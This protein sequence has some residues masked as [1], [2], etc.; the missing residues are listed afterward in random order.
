[1]EHVDRLRQVLE[2]AISADGKD[3]EAGPDR[4]LVKWNLYRDAATRYRTD[5]LRLAAGINGA[6]TGDA[7]QALGMLEMTSLSAAVDYRRRAAEDALGVLLAE[8]ARLLAPLI[9]GP[10]ELVAECFAAQLASIAART[11]PD[12]P[13]APPDMRP[14]ILATREDQ[15]AA[16]ERAS[17]QRLERLSPVE[18]QRVPGAG[19]EADTS[20]RARA[21]EAVKVAIPVWRRD[22]APGPDGVRAFSVDWADPVT[23][24][25]GGDAEL[26]LNIGLPALATALAD[27]ERDPMA[28]L[29]PL[30]R[31]QYPP[32]RVGDREMP[33]SEVQ[34]MFARPIFVPTATP[35][36][37]PPGVPTSL[38]W[39]PV[40]VMSTTDRAALDG[41]AA[42]DA[43]RDAA[44]A[45]ARNVVA[46]PC[47]RCVANKIAVTPCTPTRC[48]AC[49]LW[50]AACGQCLAAIKLPGP[51]PA[52]STVS[53]SACGGAFKSKE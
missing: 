38:E 52:G 28:D 37:R 36:P 16:L 35:G 1:M 48:G 4:L 10:P 46:V 3:L 13:P 7:T 22:V 15:I 27:L 31:V 53:C 43:A 32:A 23:V 6:Y 30:A 9:V 19:L 51:L 11:N 21:I 34:A 25:S 45:S 18:R 20:L 44:I 29:Q 33:G 8:V 2:E 14:I 47:P 26:A 12:P 39:V 50:F 41:I 42:G 5:R 17:G 40:P 49:D 24:V